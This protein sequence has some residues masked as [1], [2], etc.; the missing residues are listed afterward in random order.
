MQGEIAEYRMTGIV[1]VVWIGALVTVFVFAACKASEFELRSGGTARTLEVSPSRGV[2]HEDTAAVD[3]HPH[4]PNPTYADYLTILDEL[5]GEYP[6]SDQDWDLSS[7]EGWQAAFP[8]VPLEEWVGEKFLLRWE[9]PR[10]RQYGYQSLHRDG[11]KRYKRPSYSDLVGLTMTAVEVRARK[12]SVSD[13]VDIVF[14]VEPGQGPQSGNR[15]VACTSGET[16]I[17][18][19]AIDD[20]VYCRDLVQARR[21]LK[22]RTVWYMGSNLLGYKG[23]PYSGDTYD[24]FIP[25]CSPVVI[26]DVLPARHTSA[27]LLLRTQDD[28]TCFDD[29]LL[30]TTNVAQVLRD[31]NVFLDSYFL[32]DPR[33]M[34]PWSDD[35]WEAI[36]AGVV[37]IGMSKDQARFSW[38]MPMD[39]HTTITASGRREQWVYSRSRYLYFDGESLTTIQE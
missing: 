1:R 10:S 3:E 5:D 19:G 30:S 24:V 20:L 26:E 22:G 34:F 12:E 11:G 18:P 4:N 14:E 23:D 39:I 17:M 29:V 16:S 35:T 27:G 9:T 6:V 2:V 7:E 25:R 28:E 13:L 37:F 15:Y 38:G 8:H 33:S 32:E 21:L 31:C 36:S